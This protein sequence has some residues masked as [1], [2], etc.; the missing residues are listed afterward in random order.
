MVCDFRN[1]ACYFDAAKPSAN[2]HERQ[3]SPSPCSTPLNRSLFES[4]YQIVREIECITKLLH[5]VG[6]SRETRHHIHVHYRA[7]GE[8]Q[9]IV[10]E[11]GLLAT[12]AGIPNSMG[13]QIDV[14]DL[15]R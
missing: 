3:Q 15:S 12:L 7:A 1:R 5:R 10:R 9:M 6:V 11:R 2:D 8:Y 13:L 4:R 14:S